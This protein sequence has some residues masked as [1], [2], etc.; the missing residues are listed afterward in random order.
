MLR[1]D[2]CSRHF[3]EGHLEP[4]AAVQDNLVKVEIREPSS[5]FLSPFIRATPFFL[6]LGI[7]IF[8]INSKFPKP[9][10]SVVPVMDR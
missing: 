6:P 1:A 3:V 7:W 9:R 5:E 4:T 2:M 10:Q 8:L